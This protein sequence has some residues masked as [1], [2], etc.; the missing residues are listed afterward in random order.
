M[1][2]RLIAF[3]IRRRWIILALVLIAAGIGVY[4]FVRLPIDAIPDITNVQIQINTEASG[5]SPLEVEQRI[6]YPIETAVAGIPMLD[7][8]RSV[9]RYGLSQVTVI[10]KDGTDI[11][12]ARQLLA[13]RIQ[14]LSAD[15]PAGIVAEM[16][17]ISSGLG[18]IYL[19]TVKADSGARKEDG[20]EYT[21]S[22][23]RS[24]QD[25]VVKPQLKNT[26][27]LADVNTI[28]GYERQ[29]HITP[30]PDRLMAYGLTFRDIA[31]SLS[32]NN[33]TAA[34]GYI[35][36]SGQQYLI[37]APGQVEN[38]EDIE[39]VSLGS[40]R[41]VPVFI[42]DVAQV[43]LG[44]ELRTGAATEDGHEVVLGT[45]FMLM[46]E[47]SRTV[48]A[49]VDA[50]MKDVQKSLPSGVTVEAV[51]NRSTL[52]DATINTVRNN[53][54]EGAI[55]VIVI[56]FL[57]L[58]NI[59]AA[60]I[61]AMVIPL[62][63]LFTVTGMVNSKVSGNLLS[64]GALDFGIIV[65][66][67]VIIVENCLRRLAE[68][69]HTLGRLLTVQERFNTVRDA[70][71]EVRQAT[72]FGELIIMIV[73]LPILTLSGVEGKMF[74]PMAMTVIMALGG[75]LILSVTFVPAALAAFMTGKVVEKSNKIM[76]WSR[77][78][79][80]PALEYAMRNKPVVL[81][82][83][84]VLLVLSGLLATRLGSEFLPSLDEGDVL[85]HALRIPG[86][87]LT[88]AVEMQHAMERA[89]KAVPEVAHVFSKIGT[90]EIATDPMPPSV[91]DT[92]VMM[93]PRDQWADPD[94]PKEDVLKVMEQRIEALPGTKYEFLQ[95]I[96]MRFQELI[97]GVRSDLG[98]KLYGDDMEVLQA[99]AKEIAARVRQVRGAEDVEIEQATGL[100]LL[101]INLNRPEIARLGLSYAD[102]QDVIEIAV[103]GKHIGQVFEGDRRS[104]IVV[105]L[106]EHLRTDIEGLKRL[107][108]PL[109]RNDE[110]SILGQSSRSYVTLGSVAT[111][112]LISGPNQISRESGKRLIIVTANVKGRDL[113][114]FVKE[115]REAIDADVT[116]PAGYWI[117]FGGQFEQLTEASKRLQVVVPIALFLVLALLFATLRSVK[118][119]LLIFTGVPLAVTGGII[120]LWLRD[121]PLSITAGVGFI[122]LS[123]MAVLNGLV[124]VS[125]IR[126]MREEGE[127]ID[128]AIYHGAVTR[129]RPV[130]MTALV[131]SLGF[132]PMAIA[133][134][135]GAEVQKPLATVV[136]GG[137]ISSTLLTLFVLP[138]LYRLVHGKERAQNA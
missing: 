45:A 46:G 89:L 19:W 40:V 117:G 41:G 55:L 73:Y 66:G 101:T 120:A 124:M 121:M 29:F 52:V 116:I 104:D 99:T 112:D 97:A 58:G 109:G 50:R 79:Y 21:S 31:L 3:S 39:N 38:I 111:L 14:A 71:R 56:L 132:L 103:G 135:T 48:S 74:F 8:S 98:I 64:L 122:A 82:S 63:M 5:Y 61:T 25:W 12:F 62:A 28:G 84:A 114:S 102:V 35:E 85:I 15:L 22:D 95:P 65:D 57:F 13:E 20:T 81:T 110:A 123:G 133:T 107:P 59:R 11:Y 49:L 70:S 137:I 129:L 92:Y 51:Y 93:K 60:I 96:Q 75:A 136:I 43:S 7:Y 6:T 78:L 80:E 37:R 42:K 34:A 36:H 30:Y 108:I 119:T 100:P 27:G 2:E 128:E 90:A 94:K 24:I 68:Q 76:E 87:S 86:T 113:G 54:I 130:L 131:A 118:D 9:S 33:Q 26:P 126:K 4:N 17:P 127:S 69:Q 18:E 138:L 1:I 47:N 115:T 53:L 10:F 77:K 16:G 91:A 67:A 44:K 88:Q 106:P 83:A 134:A 23:L 32:R 125:F 72:M 105:R